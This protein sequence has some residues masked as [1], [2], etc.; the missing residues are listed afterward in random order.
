MQQ[1]AFWVFNSEDRG[2]QH[3]SPQTVGTGCTGSGVWKGWETCNLLPHPPSQ[4]SCQVGGAKGHT[5]LWDLEQVKQGTSWTCACP[6]G[7]D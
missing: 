6:T 5:K 3:R 1:R 7:S 2:A 4:A